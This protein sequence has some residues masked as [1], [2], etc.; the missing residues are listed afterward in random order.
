MQETYHDKI[1]QELGLELL[2]SRRWYRCLSCIFKIM[3]KEAP[4]YLI[5]LIPKLKQP[6]EQEIKIFRL[7]IVEQTV[8]SILFSLLLCVTGSG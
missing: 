4:S 6:S 8:S 3:R 7:T 2:K 1:Y 5:N